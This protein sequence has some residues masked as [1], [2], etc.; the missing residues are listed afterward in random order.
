[1]A[2]TGGHPPR[3]PPHQPVVSGVGNAVIDRRQQRRLPVGEQAK[4]FGL[5]GGWRIGRPDIHRVLCR[6]PN[7]VKNNFMAA[8]GPHP[9][10]IPAFH[11]ANPGAVARHQPGAHPRRVLIASRPNRQPAQ[12]FNAG[13]INFMA[14]DVPA[15]RATGRHGV[16]QA[17]PRRGA[18]L[19]LD[20]QA[21]DEATVFDSI[22]KNLLAQRR[23]PG[24]V[25]RQPQMVQILHA[26]DQRRRRLTPGD[27]GDGL[28]Q[29][30]QAGARAA[31]STRHGEA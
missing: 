16:R 11:H 27:G 21:V 10:V 1:M 28:L 30:G 5:G 17:A 31:V 3:Q 23:V 9:G 26:D 18:Q 6:H 12:P 15:L 13:G 8:G 14:A 7:V 22:V 25:F 29:L 4:R 2:E 19:R 20:A 24:V